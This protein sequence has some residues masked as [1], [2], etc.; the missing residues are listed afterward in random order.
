MLLLLQTPE[1]VADADFAAR[2]SAAGVIYSNGFDTEADRQ[3]GDPSSFTAYDATEQ[4]SID[5]GQKT[6]GAGA[7]K[8]TLRS[9]V[10]DSNIAGDWVHDL[11]D[12]FGAGETLYVQWRQRIDSTYSS[13]CMNRWQSSVKQCALTGPTSLCQMTEFMTILY[14]Q[15][16]IL[17]TQAYYH[18]GDGIETDL[19]TNALC[20]WNGGLSSCSSGILRQQGTNSGDGYNGLYGDYVE[21]DGNGSG[22]FVMHPN[23]WVTFLLRVTLG[24]SGGR[25]TI[26]EG[27]VASGGNAYK[28]YLRC[29]D[30]AWDNSAD[31]YISQVYLGQYMTELALGALAESY[32]WIDELIVSTQ[33]IAA[34]NN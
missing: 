18:C 16:T 3:E 13:N 31:D 32:C 26:V 28:Q 11:G 17:T 6:S 25:N 22:F 23:V 9:G 1:S 20:S 21:G 7:L 4:C 19:D 34:P 8:W 10:T 15:D 12:T 30:V 33:S 29:T 2:S 14:P 27:W 5:T 24:T